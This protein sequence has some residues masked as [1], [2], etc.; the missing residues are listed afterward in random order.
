VTTIKLDGN[1]LADAGG[2]LTLHPEGHERWATL[3]TAAIYEQVRINAAVHVEHVTNDGHD[4]IAVKI[5]HGT[6]L[7]TI[8]SPREMSVLSK[9]AHVEAIQA[10]IE[11]AREGDHAHR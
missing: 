8:F 7:V 9:P 6:K 10:R 11:R 2:W 3:V 4:Y 1:V 5:Q